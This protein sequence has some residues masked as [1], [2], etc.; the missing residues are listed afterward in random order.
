MNF[1]FVL[2]L[3]LSSAYL[4]QTAVTTKAQ[5]MITPTWLQ[6]IDGTIGCYGGKSI[7]F[8]VFSNTMI[9]STLPSFFDYFTALNPLRSV[10]NAYNC[11]LKCGSIGTFSSCVAFD[12]N[13]QTKTCQMYAIKTEDAFYIQNGKEY[14]Y[15]KLDGQPEFLN[16][17]STGKV[18][19]IVPN[20]ANRYTGVFLNGNNQG[21]N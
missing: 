9:D 6:S 4:G 10:T 17:Y 15:E 11:C 14:H 18:V 1:K 21:I 13:D 7:F 12:Y 20:Q 8:Q 5:S 3:C 19:Y 2:I 16:G